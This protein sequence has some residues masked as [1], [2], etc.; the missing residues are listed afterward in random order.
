MRLSGWNIHE[1]DA[2]A[3][4]TRA[5]RF[6]D[7]RD[8]SV[9][10]IDAR[11]GLEVDAIRGEA[12]F[13]RGSLRALAR[14]GSVEHANAVTR[15]LKVDGVSTRLDK[16]PSELTARGLRFS[17]ITI[18]GTFDAGKAR[19]ERVTMDSPA[20]G[21]ALS[22]EVDLYTGQMSLRGLAA[23]F[24]NIAT[25]VKRVPLVGRVFGTHI[26]GIPISLTGDIRD[27]EVVPLGPAAVGQNI[28]N[29]MGA[30]IKAPIDLIDPNAAP[31]R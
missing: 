11:S 20:V 21:I 3:V 22:G 12:G 10:V 7:R 15:I 17:E 9:A 13:L 18:E 25:I 6:E 31:L 26:V 29:L 30:V 28:V 2:P 14:D 16:Q 8:G 23:P 24:G 27:P 4:A 19:V 1:P 5:L